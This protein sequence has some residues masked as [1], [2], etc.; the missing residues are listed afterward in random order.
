MTENN[1]DA[2]SLKVGELTSR[3]EFGKGIARLDSKIMKK[4]NVTEGDI[5][6][7]EGGKKTGALGVRSYPEDVGSNLIRVDGLVRKNAG[8]SVGENVK[9]RKVDAEPADKVT[10]APAQ[11]RVAL[12]ISPNILKKN[13]YMRP[14]SKGDIIIPTSVKSKKRGSLFKDF[15]GEDIFSDMMPGLGGTE[16]R[17]MVVS[18][19]PK[20]IVKIDEQ[21]SIDL[22]PKA[23]EVKEEEVPTVTYEDIGGLHDEIKKVREMIEVPLKHP[24]VFERLGIEP[25]KG[26]LLHGPPGT[27]K[28]LLA[29]AVANEAGA[30]F[31]IING[32]EV[33]SKFYGESEKKVREIFEEAEENSPSII[34]ID[35]IDAIA[36]KREEASGEVE[37]R[38]VSQLLTLMDGL[39]ARG[40]VIVIAATNRVDAVDP[41]LRRPGRFDRE[42]EI[43]VPDRKGRKEILQ[44]HTR[45]MPLTDD[46]GLDKISERTYGYVGADI[47]ALAKESAMHALRRVLPDISDLKD[48]DEL[49]EEKLQKL[50]VSGEDFDYAMRMVEPS[51]M[52]E[53]LIEVPDVSWEDVG[54]LEEVKQR[55]REAVEWPLQYPES[56]EN[57]GIRPP[58]GLLLYGPPGC[59]KTMLAKAVANKSDSNFISVKGPELLSKWVGESEKRVR[60]IFKK[61]KQVAP[62]VV[63]FDELDALASERG[64]SAG[65]N[66]S[67]RVVSQI[68]TEMSGLE[69]LNDVIV[70]GATNRPDMI[71][72]ALLRPGRFD[73][74]L[75]V[76]SPDE[77]ARLEIFKIHTEGTPLADDIDLENLAEKTEGYSGADVAAICRE[78]ALNA[79]R[80]DRESDVVEKKHFEEAMEDSAKSITEDMKDYYEDFEA[81]RQRLGE[82][83]EEI[84]YVG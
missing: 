38:V 76:P 57:L 49:P 17:L 53:V 1:N 41:A 56:Y 82:E 84:D 52:R 54:G 73:N 81:S 68:L 32:P 5:I 25:P 37:K 55:L 61:A 19:K 2:V 46:V 6:E 3:E 79:L 11:E 47:E 22:K 27:G 74:Q 14:A 29:K 7:I 8:T 67:E 48:M 23:V 63:F 24:E 30:H 44:I 69:E 36:S 60:E 28:T 42:I 50:Q 34:F 39:E 9:V 12:H 70:I 31:Q 71:D 35:E 66:V 65:E 58:S 43:G 45:H 33:M 78:A 40:Q 18:T 4:L 62:T 15:F 64:Q 80:E 59:G 77:D 83:E 72:S 20:G 75:L 13:L 16:T 21:T 26:V 51:A 10:L